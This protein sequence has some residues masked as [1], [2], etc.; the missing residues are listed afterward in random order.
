[1]QYKVLMILGI[2]IAFIALFL[3][4][5][6]QIDIISSSLF[7]GLGAALAA[8]GFNKRKRLDKLKG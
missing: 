1:M 8:I 4:Y 5:T 3:Y 2:V 7:G 6:S